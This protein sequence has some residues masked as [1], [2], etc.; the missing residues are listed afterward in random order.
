MNIDNKGSK[1]NFAVG[2]IRIENLNGADENI[3][4]QCI[5]NCLTQKKSLSSITNDNP[6]LPSDFRQT[7]Y[8]KWVES[9]KN[10]NIV[11]KIMQSHNNQD[12][13]S[14]TC[15]ND[16]ITFRVWYDT[17][18]QNHT[19]GFFSKI[20]ILEKSSEDLVFDLKK[21]LLNGFSD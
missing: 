4:K 1:D 9:F 3:I 7:I 16:S 17:S 8:S 11:L 2:N 18:E 12:I 6:K 13:F 21:I 14:A 20:E 15:E 19:K 5:E 10:E